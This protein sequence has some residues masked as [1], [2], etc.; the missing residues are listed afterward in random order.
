MHRLRSVASSHNAFIALWV[1][2]AL[3][4]FV[5]LGFSYITSHPEG[6]IDGAH[7]GDVR[8]AVTA[9]GNQL[10]TVSLLAPDAS[11]HIERA[12][13]SYVTPA[14]LAEWMEYPEQAP[15]RHTSSPWPDHIEID[16]VVQ[17]NADTYTVSG[18][19]MLMDSTG[20]AG[21]VPVSLTVLGLSEGFRIAAY[22]EHR[23]TNPAE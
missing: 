5:A 9:F 17:N 14:L 19:I 18:R 10:Q 1:V 16:S 2:G 13:G 6:I 12:Y 11:A 3:L 23:D 7:E 21:S 4:V 20:T 8:I 22:Q 15:G